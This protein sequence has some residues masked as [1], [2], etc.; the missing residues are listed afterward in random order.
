MSEDTTIPAPKVST[1][2][3][4]EA[5]EASTPLPK[6][7]SRRPKPPALPL[8]KLRVEKIL[9]PERSIF[10]DAVRAYMPTF[11]AIV[12]LIVAIHAHFR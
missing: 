6:R 5:T 9:Y 12:A 4:I 2:P 3:T 1:P 10:R 7:R 8:P 11:I